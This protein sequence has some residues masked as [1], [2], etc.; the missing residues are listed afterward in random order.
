[1]SATDVRA[2]RPSEEEVGGVSDND[3]AGEE[4]PLRVMFLLGRGTDAY[5]D[6]RLDEA[7]ACYEQALEVSGGQSCWALHHL[8]VLARETGDFA[9]AREMLARLGDTAE[10]LNDLGCI[11]DDEGDPVGAQEFWL[12]AIEA[13]SADALFNMALLA[14][15]QEDVEEERCWLIRAA[16]AGVTQALINLGHISHEQGDVDNAIGWYLQAMEHHPDMAAFNLGVVYRDRG[17][18]LMARAWFLRAADAY[19]VD[20]LDQLELLDDDV[21]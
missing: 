6:G 11:A 12:R 9:T 7:R 2:V 5:A 17:D 10:A 16:D 1:M 18:A 19:N 21:A 14:E 15:H 8:A 20:A 4:S 3:D 13:G